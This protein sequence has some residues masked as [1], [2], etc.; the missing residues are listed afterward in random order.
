[1]LRTLLG[2]TKDFH[3]RIE[4]VRVPQ[5]GE[6]LEELQSRTDFMKILGSFP[7]AIPEED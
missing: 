7:R 4:R 3:A 5:V 6:A 2:E 1:M